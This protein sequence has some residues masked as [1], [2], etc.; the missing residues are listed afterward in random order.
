MITKIQLHPGEDFLLNLIFQ[1]P[2]RTFDYFW[3]HEIQII[4][5]FI[6]I[7]NQAIRTIR[8]D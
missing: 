1:L 4:K 2:Q 8:L 5:R 7:L 3:L 6:I